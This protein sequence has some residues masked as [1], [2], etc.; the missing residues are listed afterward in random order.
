MNSRVV[1]LDSKAEEYL[2]IQTFMKHNFN[3]YKRGFY[4]KMYTVAS[5]VT[6]S[7]TSLATSLVRQLTEHQIQLGSDLDFVKIQL[8]ELVNHPKE[9][10]DAKKGE[11]GQSS[12]RSRGPSSKGPGPS[13][14]RGEET[15]SSKNRNG[16]DQ[17]QSY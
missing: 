13:S 14:K 15:S 2:N 9:T 17:E 7:Q 3:I 4:D 16:F 12:W 1:S 11:G 5:N 10:G 8:A 6:S